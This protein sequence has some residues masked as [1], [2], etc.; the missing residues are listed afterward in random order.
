MD[1]TQ[2][3]A[4]DSTNRR[5]SEQTFDQSKRASASRRID[6]RMVQTFRLIWL[7][8]NLNDNNEEFSNTVKQ[9]R[10]VV[11]TITMF[12][13][14]EKCVQ[15]INSM[16]DEKACVIIEKSFV[17]NI[18]PRIHDRPQIH[19]IFI[20]CSSRQQHERLNKYWSKV[21][22][23]FTEN[24]QIC[25]TL[26]QTIHQFE[27]NLTSIGFM[28]TND[29]ISNKNLDQLDCSFMYTQIMKEIILAIKFEE[30]SSK[31]FIEECSNAFAG[32][33]E[34]MINLKELEQKYHHHTPIWWY[35]SQS[36]L[37]PM[38]NHALRLM[39]TD[40][41]IKI[42][43]YI[44][45]LH[46]QIEQLYNAQLSCYHENEIF[47]VYRGQG[48][49][50]TDFE[51]MT[52]TKGG[53]I[54]FNNFLSTS[55]DRDVSRAFAESNQANQDLVGILF[56]M[57]IDPSK[58]ITPFALL[59]RVSYFQAEDEVLF[60]M[61]TVFRIGEIKPLDDTHRLFQVNLTLTSDNDRDLCLLAERIRKE[62]DPDCKEW[63]R[64]GKLLLKL[65]QF[66]K[67][68]RVY[69]T[70]VDQAT[71]HIE[72]ALA[73]HYIGWAKDGYG[74]YG[75]ALIS[76]E[77]ALEIRERSLPPNH[78]DLAMTYNNI[79]LV[80]QTLGE[81]S[82]ALSSHDK[83][84][85]IREQSFPHNDP[86]LAMSYG[87]IGLLYDD[88][89]EYSKALS[90]HQR[91]LEI[92]EQSLPSNHP[93]L[94]TTYNNVGSVYQAMGEYSK[95]LLY[96]ERALEIQQ[97]SLPFDHPDLAMSYN[98]IGLAYMEM[99]EYSKALLSYEKN[100]EINTKSLPFDHPDV[101]MSYNNIGLVYVRIN[102]YS[103]ALSSH[104]I[105]V[106]ICRKSL[107][108][109]HPLLAISYSNIGHVHCQMGE[110]SQAL[111]FYERAL[112]IRQESLPPHHPDL[113]VSYI[114][115]GFVYDNTEDY[116]KAIISYTK[117]LEIREQYLPPNHPDLAM[118][119]SYIGN[120]YFKKNEYSKAL[121]FC[122]RAV[123]IAQQ[124]LP[125]NHPDRQWYANLLEVVKTKLNSPAK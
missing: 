88:M 52:K 15:F 115:H 12:T 110:Y 111:S 70:L 85:K 16:N 107:P 118:T 77:R 79:G 76:Y 18:I 40:I 97:R 78:P 50:K 8:S 32:N 1:S 109:S 103:N 71:N 86:I 69:E 119:H 42:S 66:D 55:K 72:E 53:L 27:E 117:A 5:K 84:L 56:V 25:S 17:Q 80:Y 116:S 45:D 104:E 34:Q 94:A 38:L 22:N 19:S 35:T 99:G 125:A 98:N 62:I 91:A 31:K 74:D 100:L 108:L 124:S 13:D 43:W 39:D 58:S 20:C 48:L 33:K 92:Q 121:P 11:S 123:N 21:K 75:G 101:A 46:R 54:S 114:S 47:T 89:G 59:S 96:Y 61:H 60:S 122:E 120:M 83:A 41:I 37:Y 73:Y 82:K 10:H 9:L 23:V 112:K 14:E 105:A 26:K 36:F 90:S 57:N 29:D 7:D 63:Y 4:D 81:Y 49:S 95:A 87:N 51:Q 3:A 93:T 44:R 64:L 2:S 6:I 67:A 24:S 106:E 113:A 68:Q 28:A 102:E 65:S 30:D